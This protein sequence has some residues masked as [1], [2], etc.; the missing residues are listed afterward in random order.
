MVQLSSHPF[1]NFIYFI[2]FYFFYLSSVLGVNFSFSNNVVLDFLFKDSQQLVEMNICTCIYDMEASSFYHFLFLEDHRIPI[3][4]M[5]RRKQK[6]KQNIREDPNSVLSL[7]HAFVVLIFNSDLQ[8]SYPTFCSLGQ[9]RFLGMHEILGPNMLA[10]L[11]IRF[12]YA[13]THIFELYF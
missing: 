7:C 1:L 12:I 11:L 10:Y 4:E 3:R 8:F 13:S 9:K 6:L 2:L 5:I